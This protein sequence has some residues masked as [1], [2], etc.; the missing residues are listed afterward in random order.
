[1]PKE[2]KT[3]MLQQHWTATVGPGRSRVK[4]LLAEYAGM[5]DEKTVTSGAPGS[6]P[7]LR[8][9]Q[10]L[11]ASQHKLS[12]KLYQTGIFGEHPFY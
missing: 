9:A 6:R 4:S 1:M 8:H 10:K 7:P 11:S 3:N 12:V 5:I 2:S